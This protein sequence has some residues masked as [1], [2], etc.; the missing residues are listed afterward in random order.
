MRKISTFALVAIILLICGAMVAA[1]FVY[2]LRLQGNLTVRENPDS[3]TKYQVVAYSDPGCTTRITNIDFPD[4]VSGNDASTTIYLKNTGAGTFTSFL[5]EFTLTDSEGV[6]RATGGERH[7]V[8]LPPGEST[9]VTITVLRGL[10][11]A[12]FATGEY[13]VSITID[14]YGE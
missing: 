3:G 14:C 2:Q 8:T 9:P 13:D 5:A 11:D 6:I 1:G 4:V 12:T 10:G 7:N